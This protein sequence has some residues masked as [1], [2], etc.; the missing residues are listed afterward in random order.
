[1]YF[2]FTSLNILF[3]HNSTCLNELH[4]L[5]ALSFVINQTNI[6][7]KSYFALFS[8]YIWRTQRNH[9]H[10]RISIDFFARQSI[11]TANQRALAH[12]SQNTRNILIQC[13]KQLNKKNFIALKQKQI[14][15]R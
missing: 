15:V 10:D 2:I 6:K 3:I 11:L 4:V 14:K 13:E 8:A 12:V 5:C 7:Y 1:M 9:S